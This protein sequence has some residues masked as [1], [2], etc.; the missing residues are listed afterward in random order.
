MFTFTATLEMWLFVRT[1][2]PSPYFYVLVYGLLAGPRKYKLPMDFD[3]RHSPSFR[4]VGE[5]N[6]Q[7]FS[8]PN[9]RRSAGVHG[10]QGGMGINF[11]LTGFESTSW[12][13]YEHSSAT[14]LPSR[15]NPT[16]FKRLVFGQRNDSD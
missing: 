9:P 3:R 1:V 11:K 15:Q 7:G 6:I 16:K 12:T 13:S 4:N 5:E 10:F 8:C 14:I 2:I